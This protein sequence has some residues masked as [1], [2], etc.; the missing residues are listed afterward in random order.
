MNFK[1]SKKILVSLFVQVWPLG[2]AP[3]ASGTFCSLFFS[4]SGYFVNL[5]L[6]WEYTLS[7]SLILM[8][9]GLWSIKIYIGENVNSDPKEVVID[10]AA[11]QLIATAAAGTNIYLHII[12]FLLFRFFDITKLGP[13][14]YIE[15]IG[16]AFG[17]MFDDILAGTV[18]AIIVLTLSFYLI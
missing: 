18:S 13:I 12:A 11:G 8:F 6:G 1:L 7:I 2:K 5:I 16:G 17:I 9:L 4:F 3:F 10:E 14:K 15:N